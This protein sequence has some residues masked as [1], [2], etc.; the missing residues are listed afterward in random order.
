MKKILTLF[1]ALVLLAVGAT[2]QKL[3]YSAVVRNSANE[4]VANKTLTV[5]VSIANSATGNPVYSETQSATTNQNGLLTLTIGEGASH[6][7][8]LNDVTWAT[9]YITTTYTI[10][11]TP[12]TN[13]VAV[14]AVPYALYAESAGNSTQVNADWEATSGAAE[15]LHKPM[16]PT[17][18]NGTLTIKQGDVTL[19]TFTANQSG[20]T[21][22]TIPTSTYTLTAG[23]IINVISNMTADEKAQLCQALNCSGTTPPTP[24]P[25]CP[26]IIEGATGTV[27]SVTSDGAE[28]MAY[29]SDYVD[30]NAS[31]TDYGFRIVTVT[32]DNTETETEFLT[33]L[34]STHAD[35]VYAEIDNEN[36][37][38]YIGAWV[39]M[40]DLPDLT[41]KSL[42][43]LA[44]VGTHY[45]VYPVIFC[46][47][48]DIVGS[49]ADYTIQGGGDEPTPTTFTCGTDNLVVGNN[50]YQTV[51]IGTQC[52]TK[53]NMREAVG[54]NG[55]NL[56][57]NNYSTTEPFYYV[58]TDVNDS[59][60]GY[61]Y[62]WEAAKLA[63]P[64]GWHLPDSTEWTTMM[65]YVSSYMEGGEYKYR[66]G[67][68]SAN[69]NQAL[70]TE[71]DYWNSEFRDPDYPC[72]PPYD[73]SKNNKTGFSA[74]PAGIWSH[75]SGFE[76]VGG[77]ATFWSYPG[78]GS[79]RVGEY[80]LHATYAN[81]DQYSHESLSAFC[82]R[83]QSVRCLKDDANSGGETSECP[84]LGTTTVNFGLETNQYLEFS[85]VVNN[86]DADKIESG[87]FVVTYTGGQPITVEGSNVYFS[88][89]DGANV[90]NGSIEYNDV[91]ELYG[92]ELTI[93]PYMTLKGDC[94]SATPVAGTS[95]N[96][97]PVDPY[98]G[99]GD[100]PTPTT[101]TCGTDNLV[102]G[103][104]TYPTVQ[105][106]AQ[107][108]TKT[109]MREAVG[110]NGTNLTS[111]NYSTTEPF[112]YVNTDVNDSIYGYYYNWEAAKLACPEGWHLPDSTEW[113]TMMVYVSSYMEGG[114]YKYRCGGDSA[115]INQALATEGD[116]WNS[117]FR[118]PDYPCL[119]PYDLSKN[120]KTG[121]SAV[122]AG[123]WSHW[124]GFEFVGGSATFWSYPGSGSDRVGEYS[125]HATYANM[126][127][128]SHESLSAFCSRGQSV[129]CLKDDANSGGGEP[130]NSCPSVNL[131]ST[132][133]E[134][135]KDDI[136][137]IYYTEF[138]Y[139]PGSGNETVTATYQTTSNGTFTCPNCLDVQAPEEDNPGIISVFV[140]DQNLSPAQ[141]LVVTITIASDACD[142]DLVLT[143][144][145]EETQQIDPIPT[146]FTCGTDNLVVGNNSYPTVQIGT[147]CWTKTNMR[148]VVGTLIPASQSSTTTAPYDT[149][150]A[151][152]YERPNVDLAT[153]G[154]Y[155]NWKAAKQVCPE[156]WHLPDSLE[157][158]A[159]IQYVDTCK[160]GQGNYKYR[161]DGT[162]GHIAKAL[163]LTSG[164]NPMND[165]TYPCVVGYNQDNNDATQ[166]SAYPAGYRASQS[167]QNGG[168]SAEFWSSTVSATAN[169]S[170]VTLQLLSPSELVYVRKQYKAGAYPVRCLKDN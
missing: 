148:E 32:T 113:T 58:N 107:C 164:W 170:A 159:L 136:D 49:P 4:L 121:F 117:E 41:G 3:S 52:W 158:N 109:N 108:W 43:E 15:I 29:T 76:F 169:G 123:I 122:P 37:L 44:A 65:V 153:S 28:V 67:G 25:D 91:V 40:S 77:S 46:N 142:N 63:C 116:Y 19:G 50:T 92:I 165:A 5:S 94:A 79:D 6:T 149:V 157:W 96:Y 93:T 22:V 27:L 124:S 51:Q 151:Y 162:Q 8:S 70:A 154:Y 66:C 131:P 74:V 47:G 89:I 18:N 56:T 106:G 105:I 78:S 45:R 68:D 140:P 137:N 54:T 14:N 85:T 10:D 33:I 102:V 155:Y 126:D 23:D 156:G 71:G 160:D 36:E 97:T 90:L 134:L 88:Y 26:N 9:A 82:S 12:V 118:D 60:Y 57:S 1:A 129:R 64:E 2:A 83:G 99:G 101:F 115:N 125:L 55:T 81:M 138:N 145:Y 120:N 167:F 34:H 21:E 69:I 100:E 150:N 24:M 146:T 161:C 53:T 139:T 75:W 111:N 98:S 103:N 13:T 42:D 166:F 30:D 152:S 61:Y 48:D 62:N 119:P 39:R 141:Q 73:L 144:T 112:Y 127:Q 130:T 110:T 95:V 31:V 168:A 80:S 16:I 163:A 87:K 143:G 114:E 147:Q 20:T 84:T 38:P 135:M 11:N 59:I 35:F 128:Y 7:G 17:V 104:N 133:F 132:T 86:Y 72:L